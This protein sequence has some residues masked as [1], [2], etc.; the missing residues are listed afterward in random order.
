MLQKTSPQVRKIV[1]GVVLVAAVL[2]I[3]VVPFMAFNMV[4][5][6]LELQLERIAQFQ[7]DGNAKWHL[8]TLTTWLVSFFYPF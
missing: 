3:A 1:I 8:L 7:A 2:M 6:I 4:N 5:P